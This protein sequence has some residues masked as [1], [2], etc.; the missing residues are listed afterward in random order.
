MPR[1]P[2]AI[3][4]TGIYHIILRSVNQ[5][6]IFEDNQDYSKFLY[7]LLD[8]KKKYDFDIYAYCLMTNH[9]HLLIKSVKKPSNLMQFISTKFVRWYNCK[10]ER[11]GHLFQERYYSVPIEEDSHFLNLIYYIHE[12]PV[13]GG[14][15]RFASEYPWSSCA[16]YHGKKSELVDIGYAVSVAGSKK[17]LM[18]YLRR[19]QLKEPDCPGIECI[20]MPHKITVEKATEVLKNLTDY[21]SPSDI[22]H[23]PKYVRN[24]IILQLH[25]KNVSNSLISRLC[26]VTRET[27]RRIVK[28]GS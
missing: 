26:G 28:L 7:V 2:R 4:S 10:Y 25:E 9:I 6:I 16:I 1:K 24:S 15:I 27:V 21:S 17:T 22:Q 14:I 11:Y 3:S 18:D 23:L 5:Q 20:Y 13:K 8:A 19:N 12:N